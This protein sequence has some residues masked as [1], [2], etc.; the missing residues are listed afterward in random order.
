MGYDRR[1]GTD[2]LA[3]GPGW[4]GSCFP[5]DT[6]ALIRIADDH[7]YD[8]ALLKEAVAANERQF[9]LVAD[10]V[11]K[12]SGDASGPITVAAW[13]LTFKA[14]TDDLRESPALSVLGRLRDR[15]IHIRAF[16]PTLPDP[17]DP[18]LAGLGLEVCDDPDIACEGAR[19]LVVLTEWPQ[20]R[21]LDL[22]RVATVMSRPAVVDT[23]NLL[24]PAAARAAGLLY[25]G[26][27]RS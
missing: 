6:S 22:A 26:R 9:D 2:H 15:S 3:P 4:G 23:R 13:G 14:A 8:F 27:G 18:H 20:F 7:G 1:I 24:E 11:V 5:K 10:Q 16:D 19:A 17:A 21:D 12:A 25:Q